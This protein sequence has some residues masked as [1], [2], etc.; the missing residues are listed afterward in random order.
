MNSADVFA[1]WEKE[2]EGKGEGEK[3]LDIQS[4]K[5]NMFDESCPD[6][7]EF[8]STINARVWFKVCNNIKSYNL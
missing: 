4:M 7:L 2:N 1:N 5:P 3:T 6:N 8:R